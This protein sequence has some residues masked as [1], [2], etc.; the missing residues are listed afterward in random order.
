MK[1]SV[2]EGKL[3]IDFLTDLERQSEAYL[4]HND[5]IVQSGFGGGSERWR[6]EREPI[7]NAVHQSGTLLDVGCANGYLLE[8]LVT[9]GAERRLKIEPYGVDC[10]PNLIELARRRL[11]HWADR[12]FIGNA[13]EWLPP[14]RFD[15]VYSLYDNVPEGF[16]AKYAQRLLTYYA[17]TG[18]IVIIGAY[19][20]RT[21]S[22][23]A[24]DVAGFL[25]DAGFRV[26]GGVSV[27]N[28]PEARFAWLTAPHASSGP[29]A[30]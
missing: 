29:D 27:G 3:P 22:Q 15:Y 2:A 17:V 23:P 26:A 7:L 5:P 13:W 21:K 16:L 11:P 1:M 4:I 10:S 12:F 30:A 18:G 19:G 6:S 20:S 25:E 28:V 9:W 24:F 14:R 8:S